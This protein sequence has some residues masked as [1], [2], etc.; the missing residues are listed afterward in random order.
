MHIAEGRNHAMN[1]LDR[2]VLEHFGGVTRDDDSGPIF[3][4]T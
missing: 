1:V 2:H 4:E 3:I